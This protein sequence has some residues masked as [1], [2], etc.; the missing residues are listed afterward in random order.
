M[1]GEY[2]IINETEQDMPPILYH[3]LFF[4]VKT[5]S[6][7][8]PTIHPQCWYVVFHKRLYTTFFYICSCTTQDL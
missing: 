3:T 5:L 1:L 4:L 7:T 8:S 6:Q 2:T